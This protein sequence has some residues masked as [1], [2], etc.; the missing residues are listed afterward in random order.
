M[1]S[2]STLKYPFRHYTFPFTSLL[3]AGERD[4]DEVWHRDTGSHFKPAV[5]IR[6]IPIKLLKSA[7]IHWTGRPGRQVKKGRCYSSISYS[8]TSVH[9][10]WADSRISLP[11]RERKKHSKR[12]NDLWCYSAKLSLKTECIILASAQLITN[13][14]P[15]PRLRHIDPHYRHRS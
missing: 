9:D 4:G 15:M 1:L 5:Q 2:H 11:D 7:T 6:T 3:W 14:P 13:T 8:P 10:A 12:W